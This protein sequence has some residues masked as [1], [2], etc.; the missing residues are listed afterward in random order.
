[1]IS[2]I[3]LLSPLTTA[4]FQS[5]I[6]RTSVRSTSGADDVSSVAYGSPLHPVTNR[7]DGKAMIVTPRRME[8]LSLG[9]LDRSVIVLSLLGCVEHNE[10]VRNEAHDD[11]GIDVPEQ[12]V[13][14]R[15][16]IVE[17]G[18]KKR[19]T[20]TNLRRDPVDTGHRIRLV[21]GRMDVQ[22]ELA[23]IDLTQER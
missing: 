6:M 11:A 9:H 18:R 22:E 3:G 21:D 1:R 15:D 14:R 13:A 17:L 8:R 7:S 2:S 5:W 12:Q 23:A 16:P 10:R 19:Q 4:S 20:Q